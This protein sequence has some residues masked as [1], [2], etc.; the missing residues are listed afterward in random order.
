MFKRSKR[1]I[2]SGSDQMGNVVVNVRLDNCEKGG[3]PFARI[4]QQKGIGCAV[5]KGTCRW[6]NCA[7]FLKA[8]K[9]G[10][11]ILKTQETTRQNIVQPLRIT[12][13]MNQEGSSASNIVIFPFD[14]TETGGEFPWPS[15]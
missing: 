3:V 15:S 2:R 4:L 1:S 5:K 12:C 8:C 9:L 13:H 11:F 6:F 10:D 14:S 7:A